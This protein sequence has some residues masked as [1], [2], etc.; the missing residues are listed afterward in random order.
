MVNE[1]REVIRIPG[2]SLYYATCTGEILKRDG[3]H[4]FLLKKSVVHNGYYIVNIPC[5]N[6]RKHS[7]KVH[8]LIRNKNNK[9]G[10]EK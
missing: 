7:R 1:S 2:Y 9:Y 10:T 6:N 3:D 4:F 8:R 5:D